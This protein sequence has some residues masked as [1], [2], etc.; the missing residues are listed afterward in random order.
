MATRK[1]V[2]VLPEP[3]GAAMRVSWPERMGGQPSTWGGVGPSGKRLANQAAMAGWN[4][5]RR[6]SEATG[7]T[8]SGYRPAVSGNAGRTRGQ[9]VQPDRG[10]R[11]LAPGATGAGYTDEYDFS[12][13][14]QGA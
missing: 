12:C 8:R 5:S 2:R 6:D 1:P 9:P 7:L 13:W 3:V 14:P 10:E 4:P 11:R